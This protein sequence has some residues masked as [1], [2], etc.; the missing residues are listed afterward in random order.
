MD[1]NLNS[2]LI[3]S[4]KTHPRKRG[5]Y[6]ASE[7]YFILN[8]RTTPEDWLNPKEK[9]I[10][11]M[12]T[13]FNGTLIHHAVQEVLSRNYVEEK[14]E[15]SDF[16]ITIVGKADYL[17]GPKDGVPDLDQ[18]WELKSSVRLMEKF[19][20][21]HEHQVKMYCSLFGRDT[22]KIFQPIMGKKSIGLKLLGTVERDDQWF[23]EQV[24]KL[25]EFNRRVEL[26]W[27]K[28]LSTQ[29]SLTKR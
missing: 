25:M 5:R 29:A 17:P 20:P 4:M 16:G 21:W 18:V 13:M 15:W 27:N 26:L 19:K 12:I 2:R 23:M 14:R 8:G 24:N 1:I 9:T 11:E 6:S 7:L 10:E 22:G 28:K 3:E